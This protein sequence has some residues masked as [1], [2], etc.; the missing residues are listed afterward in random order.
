MPRS[1]L[2]ILAVAA[3][4][5]ALAFAG[6]GSSD[7]NGTDTGSGGGSSSSASGG[8]SGNGGGGGGK[9]AAAGAASALKLSADPNGALKFD[10]SSLSAKSGKVTIDFTNPGTASAPH[11]V[12]VEGNGVEEETDTIQPGNKSSVTVDLKPGTYEFY[13][14]VDGHKQAGMKGTLTVQ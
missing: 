10:K 9:D 3:A 14:P 12:E 8:G 6:C 2:S 1:G 7:D 11:A 5:T 4:T 13:C